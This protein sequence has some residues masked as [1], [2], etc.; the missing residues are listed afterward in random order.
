MRPIEAGLAGYEMGS[1]YGFLVPTGT[2]EEI[3][4]KLNADTV[5]VLDSKDVR[6][7]LLAQ[8]LEAKPTT[9]QEF[10]EYAARDA[11][12]QSA[13]IRKLGIKPQ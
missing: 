2:A 1:W 13:L 12:R 6:A 11:E 10:K 5:R 7:L 3:V 8:G 4:R 9:P